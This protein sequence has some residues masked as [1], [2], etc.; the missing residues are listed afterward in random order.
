MT[1]RSPFLFLA[2][3]ALALAA[4]TT[5]GAEDLDDLQE[6][7]RSA[8]IAR[9]APSVVQIITSGGTEIIGGPRGVRKGIGPTSGVVVSADG[10]I[11]S[12]AFNFANKPASIL[13]AIPG[14]KE[15]KVAKVVCTDQ[16]RML[17]LLKV[18][19]TGLTVPPFA[20]K[21]DIKIG[22]TALALGR[23]FNANVSEEVPSVHAGII[24]A[25]DRI[26]GKAIQTDAKVSPANYGGPLVDLTGRVQGIMPR[27][28][29]S[30]RRP[31]SS[32]TNRASASPFRSRMFSP[33]CRA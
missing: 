13:V 17:T 6:K 25:K 3:A 7:A 22:H 15:T 1:R 31:A 10:Y 18:D 8:A 28:A 12:S 33:C 30:A 32:G 24:S 29:P 5:R 26:W 20:P 4:N 19:A 2:I 23:T 9:V 14:Q 21:A 11:I 27:P 16:T